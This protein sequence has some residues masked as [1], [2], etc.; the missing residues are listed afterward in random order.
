MGWGFD[1]KPSKQWIPKP[2]HCKLRVTRQDADEMVRLRRQVLVAILA[3]N[4]ASL[5]PLY[6]A[7]IEAQDYPKKRIHLWIRTNNNRDNTAEILEQWIGRVGSL[8][9][10]VTFDRSDMPVAI[11]D[12]GKHVWSPARFAA[13]NPIRQA[14][15]VATLS[16]GC[17]A[18]FVSDCDNFLRPWTLPDMVA[19][20]DC[21]IQAPLLRCVDPDHATYSNYHADIDDRGWF[22]NC[23]L[24]WDLFEGRVA[25]SIVPVVHCTYLVPGEYI[26]VLY[27][28]RGDY[29]GRYDY[30]VFSES[31]R[32][33]RVPQWINGDRDYGYLTFGD[34]PAPV[35]RA[36][37]D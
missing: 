36:L 14:S 10:G 34:D 12:L 19:R 1:G 9:R 7:C 17:D 3:R 6:L 33:A 35:I 37:G 22:R 4:Q 23:P 29:D 13:L 30:V 5:L 8:Y 26:P 18:Y 15:L 21:G 27:Y 16:H 28:Q 32:A 2:G 11:D 24:Y 25:R 31:A 20:M